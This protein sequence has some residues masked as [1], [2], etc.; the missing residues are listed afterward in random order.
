MPA[1]SVRSS[2]SFASLAR[3]AIEKHVP[4]ARDPR[5]HWG[6]GPNGAWV[7]WPREG[8]GFSYLALRRHLDWVTGEAGISREPVAL[9]SL[10]LGAAGAPATGFRVRLG[11]LLG[12]EDRWWPVGAGNGDQGRRLEWIVLQIRV[13]AEA[14][15]ARHLEG[16]VRAGGPGG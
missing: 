3:A 2:R 10:P 11:E 15:F 6:T 5:A 7:R 16:T 4:E 12:D 8:G 9:G 13:K 14:Y 1:G